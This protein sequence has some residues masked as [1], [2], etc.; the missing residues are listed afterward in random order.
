MRSLR[1]AARLALFMACLSPLATG[2]QQNYPSQPLKIVVPFAPGGGSDFIGRFIADKLTKSLGQTVIVDNRP[3]A[4]GA[5][6]AAN[7]QQAAP[8]GYTLLGISGLQHAYL[9]ATQ[10]VSY[11]PVKGFAPVT[12]LF[13]ECY[14]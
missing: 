8:D 12:L 14:W 2:A 1:I 10:T 4:G 13:F 7:V 9:P 5:T 6:A 11:E 3:G